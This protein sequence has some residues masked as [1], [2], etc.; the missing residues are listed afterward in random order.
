MKFSIRDLLWLTVVVALA[1]GW[2]LSMPPPSLDARV[3]GHVSVSGAPLPQGR[4]L[5]H[6]ADGPIVG[7]QVTAGKFSL[8]HVPIGRFSVTVDGNG[9]P[10]KYADQNAGLT[11][12]VEVGANVIDFELIM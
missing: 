4:V 6:S 7:A 3:S 8:E 9:V 1:V 2:W 5:F 12:E 11:V 10:A